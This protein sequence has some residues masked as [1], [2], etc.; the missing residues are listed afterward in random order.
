MK[1]LLLAIVLIACIKVEGQQVMTLS[2]T[3]YLLGSEKDIKSKNISDAECGLQRLLFVSD[4]T[5]LSVN[6]CKGYEILASGSYSLTKK[7]ITL[8]YSNTIVIRYFDSEAGHDM[9]TDSL[10]TPK[11]LTL[12]ASVKKKK[13]HFKN[14]GVRL[15]PSEGYVGTMLDLE[16][17]NRLVRL[18]MAA[19]SNIDI[20]EGTNFYA[21]YDS[22]IIQR[23]L[24]KLNGEMALNYFDEENKLSGSLNGGYSEGKVYYAPDGRFKIFNFTGEGCGAHCSNIFTTFIQLPSGKVYDMDTRGIIRLEEYSDDKY[25]I[26]STAWGGGTSGGSMMALTLFAVDENGVTYQTLAPDTVDDPA[27][28]HYF[29]YDTQDFEISVP[30]WGFDYLEMDY[31]PTTKMVTYSYLATDYSYGDIEK[32]LPEGIAVKSTDEG[33]LVSGTFSLVTGMI[34]DFREEYKVVNVND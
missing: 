21:K 16:A 34:S 14:G 31:D 1:K 30:W 15:V 17:D 9:Y 6:R 13:L 10:V 3:T 12:K 7:N 29:R 5:F 28:R 19:K 18:G 33:L 8:R 4:S 26:I 22:I 11:N 24:D 2:N 32:Y 23:G 20:F 27:L 25:L